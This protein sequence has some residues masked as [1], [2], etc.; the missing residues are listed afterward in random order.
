MEVND[1]GAAIGLPDGTETTQEADTVIMSIGCRPLPSMANQL[2]GCGA[3]VYETGDGSKVGN[4]LTCVRE[5]F[6]VTRNL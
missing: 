2:V 6:V 3:S 4:V 1:T 5:A